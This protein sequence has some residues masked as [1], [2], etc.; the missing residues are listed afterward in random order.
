MK[1]YLITDNSYNATD[2]IEVINVGSACNNYALTEV[3]YDYT[4]NDV[5]TVKG[6]VVSYQNDGTV[7]VELL[8]ND[9]ISV[10][11]S[12]ELQVS[13]EKPSEFELSVDLEKFQK[14][15]VRITN[16][17]G[18][19]LDNESVIFNVKSENSYKTLLVSDTPFFLETVLDVVSNADVKV[20]TPDEYLKKEDGESRD[21]TGYGLYIFH[22]CN[23]KAVPKD[24]SVWLI[25]TT[26]SIENSGFNYQGENKLDKAETIVK[27]KA[28]ATMIKKLLEN[29]DGS[30][31]YIS[32]YSKYDV[33]R[34]FSTLF[35][36]EGN[37]LIF[38]GAN[39]YG[40]REV[41]F[42]FDLHDSDMPLLAD[43][44]MLVKNLLD[45]SFPV[46]IEKTSY[47]CGE[48]A[49]INVIANCESIRVDTPMNN[50][51]HLS[52]HNTVSELKLDEVGTYKI[53]AMISGQP[54]EFYIYSAMPEAEREPVTE[55]E[56]RIGLSGE[57]GEGGLDA[58]YDELIV[59]FIC[60][61]VIF[62]AEWV[63]YC[64]EKYQLR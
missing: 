32:K 22:S 24:G 7:T 21:I 6:K 5:L 28:S 60:L 49:Q 37:P 62:V 57:A 44:V 26:K 11:K 3:E 40:N 10:S 16:E 46:V 56:E 58:I 13:K 64:Y 18:L 53:T 20:M 14:A 4:M 27:S 63:V 38:T 51:T 55:P 35:T 15:V 2:N 59:F 29:V 30:E 39:T 31:I 19:M 45:F 9:E 42:A 48:N 41:V 52:V 8:V 50:V 33:Y 17:D 54:R 12:I 61:A 1:T 36:H 34:N 23:P 25:N 43:Y 47:Y